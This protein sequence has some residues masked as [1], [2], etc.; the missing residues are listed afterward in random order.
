MAENPNNPNEHH[1]GRSEMVNSLETKLFASLEALDAVMADEAPDLARLREL[2][3]K[4]KL[5]ER[6]RDVRDLILFLATALLVLT[7]W[8]IS[9]IV[10]PQ[11]FL[12]L[13][14]AISGLSVLAAAIAVYQV[15]LTAE[16]KSST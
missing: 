15:A 13:L 7:G 5:R 6:R 9:L 10:D 3:Q 16:R 14:L 1:R 4:T 12:L 8:G 11:V 2:V